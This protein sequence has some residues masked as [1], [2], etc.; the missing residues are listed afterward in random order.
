[1][2]E[3]LASFVVFLFTGLCVNTPR[4]WLLIAID[5]VGGDFE[6]DR[7]MAGPSAGAGKRIV[8]A[9]RIPE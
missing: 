6:S 7:G 4:S 2:T 5:I 3:G 9:E 8:V 1:M